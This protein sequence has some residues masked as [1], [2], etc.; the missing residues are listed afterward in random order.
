ME[1]KEINLLIPESE[2]YKIAIDNKQHNENR[3]DEINTYYISLLAAIIAA[4]PFIDKITS[5]AP[6]NYE[7]YIIRASLT[8]LSLIGLILAVTWGLNL[9][10]TLFYLQS[11]DKI[12]M[13][14]E[15]KYKQPFITRI[16]F[17]LINKKSPDRITKYQLIIPYTFVIIF[18]GIIVY[19]ILWIFGT[20][21]K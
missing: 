10:R 13:E 19:S 1:K 12:I 17:D 11:L 16:S 8:I 4:I 7:G 14:L 9:K 21:Q 2:L 18:L 15:I 20:S 3:R 6:S 5:I